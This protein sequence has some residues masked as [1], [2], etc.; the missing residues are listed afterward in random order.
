MIKKKSAGVMEVMLQMQDYMGLQ[1]LD[2]SLISIGCRKAACD[3]LAHIK[4]RHLLSGSFW[5]RSP[6]VIRYSNQETYVLAVSTY[7]HPQ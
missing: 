3:A 1:V 5:S 6:P 2:R 7:R 4:R